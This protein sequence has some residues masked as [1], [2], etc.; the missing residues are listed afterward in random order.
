ME[1]ASALTQNLRRW[2]SCLDVLEDDTLAML[3]TVPSLRLE[4]GWAKGQ[5]MIRLLMTPGQR[6]AATKRLQRSW[7]G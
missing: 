2:L 5:M 7:M 3:E 1:K 6:L 4:S